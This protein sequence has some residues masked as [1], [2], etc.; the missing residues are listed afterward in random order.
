MVGGIIHLT[1]HIPLPKLHFLPVTHPL[2]LVYKQTSP[3]KG[4]LNP[5]FLLKGRVLRMNFGGG[6]G[7]VKESVDKGFRR[8]LGRKSPRV[9][10][11]QITSLWIS[12]CCDLKYLGN[13]IGKQSL[14]LSVCH[15]KKKWG[16]QITSQQSNHPYQTFQSGPISQI[17]HENTP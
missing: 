11:S 13:Q 3:S 6:G 16:F 17:S 5:G 7:G 15:K 9:P 14:S 10:D 12:N 2:L 1:I 8:V 4:S